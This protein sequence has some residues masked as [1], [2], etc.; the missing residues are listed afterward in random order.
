MTCYLLLIPMMYLRSFCDEDGAES[1]LCVSTLAGLT[2]PRMGE[3]LVSRR[4][5]R[6]MGKVPAAVDEPRSMGGRAVLGCVCAQYA[7]RR[8]P[9]FP[10]HVLGTV[11]HESR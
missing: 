1:E 9:A 8:R 3:I 5:A 2:A 7:S 11:S 10:L 6:R 4:P